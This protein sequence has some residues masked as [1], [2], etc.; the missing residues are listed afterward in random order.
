MYN[1]KKFTFLF[2]LVILLGITLSSCEKNNI[3]SLSKESS[4][5]FSKHINISDENGNE[6]S[7]DIYT[8][9]EVILNSISSTNFEFEGLT[10]NDLYNLD[11]ENDEQEI[12]VED[13]E[14]PDENLDEGYIIET[15]NVKVNLKPGFKGYSLSEDWTM[16]NE[17]EDRGF[18]WHSEADSYFT[19]AKVKNQRCCWS[20]YATWRYLPFGYGD[21]DYNMVTLVE[22]KRIRGGSTTGW[23]G[24]QNSNILRLRVKYRRSSHRKVY[25]ANQSY[26]NPSR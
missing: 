7:F 14:E 25:Y 8:N 4:L 5:K 17:L 1:T 10:E 21:V 18:D 12:E 20:I 6:I 13:S 22:G 9:E 26:D 24:N 11:Q 19:H 15:K 2:M 3:E 16:P 23:Y